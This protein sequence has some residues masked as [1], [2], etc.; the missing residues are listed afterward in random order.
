LSDPVAA[1]V[2]AQSIGVPM[3]GWHLGYDHR[4]E[5]RS[6]RAIDGLDE[7]LGAVRIPVQVVVDSV[8]H[9]IEAARPAPP[10]S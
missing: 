3:I 10:R 1:A 6:L 8:E 9:A 2:R 5:N 7:V 4:A